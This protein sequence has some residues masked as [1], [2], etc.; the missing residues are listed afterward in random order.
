MS[1]SPRIRILLVGNELLDGTVTD[2]NGAPLARAVADRGGTVEDLRILPD[3]PAALVAGVEDALGGGRG[4]IVAGGVGP[5]R[6]DSTREAVAEALDRELVEWPAWAARLREEEGG[7]GPP[8]DGSLRQARIPEGGRGLANPHGTAAGFAGRVGEGW[9]LVLPGVPAELRAMLDGEAGAFL[10]EVLPGEGPPRRRVGIA[11]VAE[12]RVARRLEG[13]RGLGDVR[14]ASYP[15]GGVV[16]LHLAPAA[17]HG[18]DVLERAVEALR[19]A[20][21]EDVYE[22]GDRSLVEVVVDGLRAAD[23]RL[24]VAE[25]CT[26]G[27]LGGEITSVPGSS[28]VFWGGATTY[29]DRAKVE[30][31]GVRPDTLSEAGAV[32]GEVA[33]EMAEGIRRRA[34]V[35]W[36]LAVT[37]VAGPGGGSEAKPVGTVWIAAAGPRG[38]VRR[39]LFPGG[40]SEVRERSV[41]AALDLLRRRMARVGR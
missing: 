6:D 27:L 40:R 7:A 31:L 37:G 17:G 4:L 5:T 22:V 10:E 9:Y 35:D 34:D 38:A 23:R 8:F 21:G 30:L 15:R 36:S 26:G 2:R 41:R 19:E 1:G 39:H 28:D 13:V 11:G 29:D 32:S 3:D 20:F 16:D 25:S 14:L 18:A 24:A 33:R 12:S